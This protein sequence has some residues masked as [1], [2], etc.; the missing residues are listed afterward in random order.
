MTKFRFS[1]G[2]ICLVF[3]LAP[4][5][6]CSKES[7]HEAHGHEKPG[8]E[9][10]GHENAATAG[11]GHGQHKDEAHDEHEGEGKEHR[12]H[13]DEGDEHEGEGKEHDDHEDEG[14]EEHEEGVVELTVEAAAEAKIR[15]APVAKQAVPFVLRTTAR[16]DFDERRLAHVSPRISGRVAKV[17]AEL[18]DETKAGDELAALDSIELGEAKADYMGARAQESLA[19]KTSSREQRLLKDKIASEQAALEARAGHE[20][21]LAHLRSAEEKLRLLGMTKPEISG[22]R[23]G[24][25]Q[26]ATY[27]LRAPIDGRIVEKHLVVGELVTPA[28]KV[29]TVADLS[30]LW[31]WID[32]YERDLARVHRDDTAVVTTEA[33]PGKSFVGHVA[34]ISDSVDPSSRAARARIDIANTDGKLKP[35]MFA[36]VVLTD[37]HSLDEARLGLAVPPSAVIREGDGF[38]AFVKEG[39]R[40]YERR[41]LRIGART[42]DLVEILEGLSEGEQVV[43]EG[44]FILKSEVAKEE[45]GGGH[46]H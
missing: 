37:P 15:V 24:D 23:Y 31:I 10:P 6:G 41:A 3:T 45:M 42:P 38:V 30:H 25:P 28:D 2:I 21:A 20:K 22:V 9:E 18:G 36:E 13:E 12:K 17:D 8:H 11:K 19:R 33:W 27:Q 34:Y 14:H 32:V 16:V 44:A 39:E 4:W 40:R 7:G 1:A 29:F 46:S 43:I 35:G 5:T 26:A